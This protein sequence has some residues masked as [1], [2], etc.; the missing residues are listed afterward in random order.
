MK[1]T[2]IFIFA[3]LAILLAAGATYAANGGP[4]L[5]E[6]PLIAGQIIDAG[7]VSVWNSR[8]NLQIQIEPL[9]DWLISEVHIFA[10]TGD[11]PTAEGNPIPGKF[12]YKAE[13]SNPVQKHTTVVH[14]ADD[15]GFYWGAPWELDRIQNIA[16][17]VDLVKLNTYGQVT[18]EEGA[19][20]YGPEQGAYISE[21]EG[22]EF[23]G[24]QW[25]W[26]FTYEMA[27]PKRGHLID[28]PVE[29][30][31]F[32]TPTGSGVTDASGG[33][34]YFPGERVELAI[35]SVNLGNTL[36]DHKISPLDIY[37][38]ADTDDPMVINMARLL[39][40]LDADA[41]PKEGI[42]ITAEVAVCLEQTLGSTSL[43]FSDDVQIESVIQ[44]TKACA[45]LKDISLVA[46]SAEDAKAHL[47]ET[48]NN[49]M[50][51]KRISRTPDQDS[52][53]AKLATSTMWF[54][55]LPANATSETEA[56][57][58]EYFDEDG[59]LIRTATEAKPIIVTFT[60]ADPVTSAH[61]T[62]AAISRDD[63]NTWKRKN[64]S[65]SGDRSSFTL[66]NGELFYGTVKKPVVQFRGNKI[67]VAWSSK[68]C[69]GGKPRYS[70]KTD[71]DYAYDDPYYTDDIWGVGGP[72][73]SFDYTDM[74]FPE[75]G[76]LPFS[77]VWICRG[78][79]A[80]GT[81]VANGL[82]AFVGDIVWFKPERLTSGRRDALQIF[83][84]GASGA[85]FAL[86][87]QEDPEGVRPGKFAGPGHG[88]S[89]ATTNHKT[90]IWYS[91]ITWGDFAKVDLNFVAGGDPEHELDVIGRP[92]ALVP[93]ALPIRLSDNDVI[94]TNNI[95][96]ELDGNGAPA[97]D[98]NGN[99]IPV[100]NEDALSE[101]GDGTHRYAYTIPGLIDGWYD[102]INYQ[103]DPKTVAYTDD[104]RLL[105]GDT[106]ASRANLFLQPYDTGEDKSDG[107][108]VMSAWAIINYEETKGAGNGPP[109]AGTI[110][111]EAYLPEQGKN[112]IY[113]SFDFKNPDLV[114][115]GTIVNL[116]ERDEEYNPLYIT[117]SEGGA[118]V[119]DWQGN[120]ILAYENARRAR[121]ILQGG[122][123]IKA[124]MHKTA[125][126][127]VYKEGR[128][129]SGRPSDIFL[130]RFVVPL[131]VDDGTE[132][133]TTWDWTV[134]NP[135]R[136]ENLVCDEWVT[137]DNG[138]DVCVDGAQNISSVTPTVT[139]ESAGD[140]EQ[141]DPYGAVKVVEWA[142]TPANLADLSYIN[143]YDDSRS[144]RGQIR[145]DYA[146]VGL[147]YTANWAAA[148]NGND[149]YDFYI[150]RT[151]DGGQT[152]TTDP[153]GSGVTHSYTWTYPSGT[154]SAGT[155]VEE[156]N[157]FNAGEF[158]SMRNLSQL[159]NSKSSVIEPRIV[160]T[161]G[162]I[163]GS[164][165]P[166]DTQDKAVYYVAYG[167]ASNPK[168]MWDPI[169]GE[170]TQEDGAPM[171]LY[172]SFTQDYGQTYHER[173]WNVMGNP[174]NPDVST[175]DEVTGWAW[176]AKG[177]Q[178]Q[179]EVQIRMTPDGSRFYSCWLDEGEEGSDI[180]FR[181]IMPSEFPCNVAT[182][183]PLP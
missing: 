96:V 156:I 106:G 131:T 77:S 175:G 5:Y 79:I 110:P 114:S 32:S 68:F 31:S 142:Q 46:V 45:L 26:W 89:G 123:A 87:W 7:T 75:V 67:L 3:I 176:L 74:G 163:K 6:T 2:R 139:T 130:R 102:Y 21:E 173:I 11:M 25:G 154:Q 152:W 85:G 120:P 183:T 99:Y 118:N 9:G 10:G 159:P 147:A 14:L 104:N 151:F 157:T 23:E 127:M 13:Y 92:K 178:E 129:G 135:Y 179:G 94:N 66:A 78:V 42:L 12:P 125:M 20:A 133:G 128:E 166:E 181:R 49:E 56:L 150:R 145:G 148:R 100:P 164:T 34:D 95:L 168:K 108:P 30:V 109:E 73:R 59:N 160:A 70:I 37:E 162:T 172:Y 29:G 124:S 141:D 115:G 41:S 91:H 39:Q 62:W 97:L 17:H 81:D 138:C 16:V 57:E 116:P 38:N 107:S 69:K 72:Q 65:R 53:K 52:S 88:W 169:T 153:A 28:S 170:M 103:G 51:R 48:L 1:T 90:D 35:G 174:T 15:M 22:E 50:F 55:A 180:M 111:S 82:G 63:G 144:H 126:L 121:F 137:A 60:D 134:H 161:P 132:T 140:P 83:M 80:T 47:D 44:G 8:D 18:D 43:D 86:V 101:I 105:D 93:M 19:W 112:V 165:R 54:P 158:E 71:D 182:E 61:D 136:V 36:A 113:H 171:D 167:T 58:I 155:K 143:P 24:S 119:L 4:G 98:A 84:G 27:H 64:I 149:K 122:G 33:F 76:E 146:C 177:D 40:S 117:E